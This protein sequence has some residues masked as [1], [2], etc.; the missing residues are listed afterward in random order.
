MRRIASVLLGCL[1]FILCYAQIPPYAGVST[2]HIYN[3]ADGIDESN[4]YV[5]GIA[6]DGRVFV[7]A[8]S[9]S[10]FV[11]GNN[12]T[13]KI[14]FPDN[15]APLHC[16]I[17]ELGDNKF[18]AIGRPYY[19]IIENDSIVKTRKLPYEDMGAFKLQGK[20]I[21]YYLNRL[22]EFTNDTFL[23]RLETPTNINPDCNNYFFTDS[24]STLWFVQR[25]TNMAKFSVVK[26][27]NSIE[28]K[29][30]IKMKSTNDCY[31]DILIT[32][33][34]LF[35]LAPFIQGG[36]IVPEIVT[37]EKLQTYRQ[38]YFISH[39]EDN[40]VELSSLDK[41][42]KRVYSQSPGVVMG[43]N[44]WDS[45]TNSF[46]FGSFTKP[47]RSFTYLKKYPGIFSSA[48][49]EI[50]QDYKNRIWV[51][52]YSGGL[53]IIDSE[54]VRSSFDREMKFMPAGF[55]Y[56]KKMYLFTEKK[57]YRFSE[58]DDVN[59]K[60]SFIYDSIYIYS[61][62]IDYNR[63][64]AYLGIGGWRGLLKVEL[65][66]LQRKGLLV[67]KFLDSNY[68][69]K[70]KSIVS[71]TQDHR[72]R[73]W[74][75]NTKG[76]S[77]YSKSTN[78]AVTWLI[79]KGEVKSG[80]WA[81][82]TDDLGTVW[83]GT[84]GGGLRYYENSRSDDINPLNIKKIE[85]PLLHDDIKIMQ[86]SKWGKW[87]L[88]GTGTDML[89]LDL[90]EWYGKRKVYVRYI[91]PLEEKFNALPEQNSIMIDKRD[92]SVWFATSD[93]LYQWDIKQWLSIQLFTVN[94]EVL[95][96]VQGKTVKIIEG[97]IGRIGPRHNTV[98]FKIW[99]QSRDNMPRYMS[100]ALNRRGQKLQLPV[101]SLQTEY[102]FENLAS[103]DYEL[104]IQICQSDGSVSLHRYPLVIRR[105][106]W[107]NWWF[108]V[109]ISL[110]FITPVI[111][112]IITRNKAK[113]AIEVAKRREAEL[114]KVRAEQQKQMASLQIISLS[115]QFRPHFIL[116][117][118]NAIGAE[119]EN[120]PH[121]ES[122]LSRLGE[123]IDIIFS[124]SLK[125]KI[126]HSLLNEWKLV[127][128]VVQIHQMM[129]LKNLEFSF[130]SD[131]LMEKYWEWQ[132][133]LGLLQVPIENS[134]LHGLSNKLD[135]PWK[136]IIEIE[137]TD[138]ALVF[139][140]ADNG[141]GRKRAA[142]LGNFRKHGIGIKNLN[143]ILEIINGSKDEKITLTYFDDIYEAGGRYFGTKTVI[144]IPKNFRY[145]S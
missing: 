40:Y 36:P 29:F 142:D 98:S 65:P 17:W 38:K 52:T 128:N 103:G 143:E 80:A 97:K 127:K 81:L 93:N 51:A 145:E 109:I 105:F 89:L 37:Y 22:Y 46:Y 124:H 16:S 85:H 78:K 138:T 118:L 71:I 2:S 123:S 54:N 107:E 114:K 19:M 134:L 73:I 115:N 44:I 141:I 67:W 144:Y 7:H 76:I 48:V 101:P 18:L 83:M 42:A 50:N 135:P 104:V 79:E 125:K 110:L 106:W 95:L 63:K 90:N 58:F 96:S 15:M 133:P 1:S 45:I 33:P 116:N 8:H 39:K 26:N 53:T 84:E 11:L 112:W 82:L 24:L 56:G 121:A 25:D 119:L 129:Y 130:P 30:S 23:L 41:P 132:V 69:I 4:F 47:F 55:S 28:Y 12:Y 136:L 100:V 74:M 140:I 92:S 99:F 77:V 20:L 6:S 60:R 32:V 72:D 31:K 86:L 10:L 43:N 64:D 5:S 70:L 61:S 34:Y 87:L 13:R 68:G 66:A 35:R 59:I 111:L 122:V 102:R 21:G 126:A 27:L 14:R 108:W 57:G 9:G 75:G 91:N 88:V 131:E 62:F 49:S 117:A 139:V 137:E 3:Q 113:L 94:P 120:K